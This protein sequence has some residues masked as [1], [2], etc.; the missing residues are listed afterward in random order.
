MCVIPDDPFRRH[1]RILALNV[2]FLS[3]LVFHG[4]AALKEYVEVSELSPRKL[5]HLLVVPVGRSRALKFATSMKK[6]F[7]SISATIPVSEN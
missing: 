7:G 4:D 1:G 6:S 3:L 2:V 5:F